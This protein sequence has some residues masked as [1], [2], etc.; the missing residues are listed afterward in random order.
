M[1]VAQT[2][3]YFD[4]PFTEVDHRFNNHQSSSISPASSSDRLVQPVAASF[5]TGL[6][7]FVCHDTSIAPAGI[8]PCV[9]YFHNATNSFLPNATMPIL[10]CR[11]LPL[12]N[13]RMY[14]W[15]SSLCAW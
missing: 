4:P 12:P 11:L 14:H 15:L 2:S 7:T 1:S 6:L 8:S 13:R 10:R 9:A 5:A 3:H